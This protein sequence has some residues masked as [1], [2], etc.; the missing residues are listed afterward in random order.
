VTDD[1]QGC[2]ERSLQGDH[3]AFESLVRRYQRMIYS[4]AYRMTGSAADAEDLAQ[5]TFIR[6]H[7]QL[8]GFRAD[9]KFSSWLYRIAVN[10]CL[11][12]RKRAARREQVYREWQANRETDLPADGAL[13]QTVQMALVKLNPKQ[14]AAVVLTTYDGLSHAEAA[15]VLGCSETT[16][17]WRLFAARSKLKRLLKDA[18]TGGATHE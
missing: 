4:L 6:A 2:V 8:G 1:D 12:W 15:R 17:S 5:E 18:R 14:R 3:E 13:A 10:H 16:V 9:A 11:N 7:Q